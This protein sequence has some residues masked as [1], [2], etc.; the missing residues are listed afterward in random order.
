[1]QLLKLL[2]N[3]LLITLTLFFS[4]NSAATEKEYMLKAGF[5]YNFARFANWVTPTYHNDNFTLCSPDETFI[6]VVRQC[7]GF[8]SVVILNVRACK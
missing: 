6:N 1:M 3:G 2:L 5:L 4:A 8:T 7:V